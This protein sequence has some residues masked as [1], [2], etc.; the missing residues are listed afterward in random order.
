MK[1][2]FEDCNQYSWSFHQIKLKFSPTYIFI[3]VKIEYFPKKS[4]LMA[5]VKSEQF[6]RFYRNLDCLKKL[7]NP[8]KQT[9]RKQSSKV[10]KFR[11]TLLN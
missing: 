10:G 5:S 9:E 1:H 4:I 7:E 11:K 6:F 3:W 8:E 2:F